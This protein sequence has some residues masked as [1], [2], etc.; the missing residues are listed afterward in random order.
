MAAF[1]LPSPHCT[2]AVLLGAMCIF[3]WAASS[4]TGLIAFCSSCVYGTSH[5]SWQSAST[6][7]CGMS[8]VMKRRAW[9]WCLVFVRQSFLL[10]FRFHP[11]CGYLC[12]PDKGGEDCFSL[13][14][15][16]YQQEFHASTPGVSSC[17]DSANGLCRFEGKD[18]WQARMRYVLST[19]GVCQPRASPSHS[20]PNPPASPCVSRM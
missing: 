1:C 9:V 4:L 15:P 13:G 19:A 6:Q 20:T 18:V 17:S 8:K 10:E 12:C 14:I 16:G 2:C 5:C 11:H 3:H 7:L